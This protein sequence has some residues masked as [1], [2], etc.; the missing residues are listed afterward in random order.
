M[1]RSG[2]L[3]GGGTSS[4]IQYD[5]A[6][7]KTIND[8]LASLTGFRL[9]RVEAKKPAAAPVAEEPPPKP[10]PVTVAQG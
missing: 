6:M 1:T 10:E 9:E 3:S 4:A 7:K 5:P 2:H 8:T